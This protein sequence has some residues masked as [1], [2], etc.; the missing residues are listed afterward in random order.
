[1]ADSNYNKRNRRACARINTKPAAQV[2]AAD[3]FAQMET[4][5]VS[6]ACGVLR[7][8][9]RLSL[10]SKRER[11]RAYTQRRSLL[12]RKPRSNGEIPRRH[13][14]SRAK[15]KQRLHSLSSRAT[16]ALYIGACSA[17]I[18]PSRVFSA[19]LAWLLS[20]REVVFSGMQPGWNYSRKAS[21]D[22]SVSGKRRKYG[23]TSE[24]AYE[25]D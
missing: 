7:Q 21:M 17:R 10:A 9:R 14:G 13:S 20:L 6:A 23:L 5:D 19:S 4:R 11:R 18:G 8:I 2:R 3:R 22:R 15:Y 25:P 1:M 24:S 16:L 12:Q